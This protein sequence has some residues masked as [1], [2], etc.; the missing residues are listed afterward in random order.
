[1]IVR[2]GWEII[3]RHDSWIN[4]RGVD[5]GGPPKAGCRLQ[6]VDARSVV[7]NS[8][9]RKSYL[10]IIRQAFLNPNPDETLLA[11]DQ[12][13]CHGVKVF[14]CPRVFGGRQLVEARDQAGR[15]F[16][17]GIYWDGSTRYLDIPPP[18]KADV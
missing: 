5:L 10:I 9:D 12:I 1:M 8:L 18:N 15:V 4:A 2:D 6:L 7:K 16:K 11:E 13:E 14:S 3:K 17:L